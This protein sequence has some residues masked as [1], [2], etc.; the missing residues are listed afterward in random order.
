VS[1]R[2]PEP[3]ELTPEVDPEQ[4]ETH[5]VPIGADTPPKGPPDTPAEPIEVVEEDVLHVDRYESLWMRLSVLILVVFFVG[6]TVSSFAQ[7]FQVPGVYARV[8]PATLFDEDSPWANPE[9]RELAPGRYEV[10]LRGQIW[11]FAPNLIEV[12]A[13]SQITFYATSLDVQHG[14]KITDTNINMMLLPGQVSTLTT[15]FDRPGTYYFICHEYCGSLH[16]TMYGQIVVTEP[17]ETAL[18]MDDEAMPASQ[19]ASH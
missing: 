3:P 6:V 14:V 1:E 2:P 4:P 5:T 8:D 15:R 11:M 16:H 13:G 18:H 10:Y 7:G 19:V 9:L 17:A 12:P